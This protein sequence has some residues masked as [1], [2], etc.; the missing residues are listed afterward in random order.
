MFALTAL[1]ALGF[2]SNSQAATQW[3]LGY[4]F[5][6]SEDGNACVLARYRAF[7][8]SFTL[9]QADAIYST[10]AGLIDSNVDAGSLGVNVQHTLPSQ[11]EALGQTGEAIGAA[12]L[13]SGVNICTVGGQPVDVV[14]FLSHFSCEYQNEWQMC[15]RLY[16]DTGEYDLT[17][18]GVNRG[19]AAFGGIFIKKE[20]WDAV[21]GI[22][23][24]GELPTLPMVAEP[25]MSQVM[26]VLNTISAMPGGGGGSLPG[27]TGELI[28]TP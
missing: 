3:W 23:Y 8:G 13:Q 28:S 19:P 10:V 27:S 22:V 9:A 6:M 1:C 17:S 18:L 12:F 26:S 21:A 20:I 24:S 25:M 5:I 11:A 14:L 2:S 15:I 16:A 4:T 7:D